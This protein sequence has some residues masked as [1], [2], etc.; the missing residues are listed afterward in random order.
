MS[1]SFF[2]PFTYWS[3]ISVPLT[4]PD[5]SFPGRPTWCL[6][7]L[8]R[9]FAFQLSLTKSQLFYYLTETLKA[10]HICL[11]KSYIRLFP[12]L[13]VYA[14]ANTIIFYVTLKNLRNFLWTQ[15]TRSL[16]TIK[17]KSYLRRSHSTRLKYWDGNFRLLFAFEHNFTF[18]R[19]KVMLVY[20]KKGKRETRLIGILYTF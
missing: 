2:T 19:C 12:E 10:L 15:I 7:S 18:F 1:Y 14:S 4:C 5:I 16:L 8:F 3:S 9:L 11:S 13:C 17:W 6:F 20:A